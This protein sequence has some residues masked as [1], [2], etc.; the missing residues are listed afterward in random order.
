MTA[1]IEMLSPREKE[2][3]SSDTAIMTIKEVIKDTKLGESTIYELMRA[4]KFP[5]N[6]ILVGRKTVWLRSEIQTWIRWRIETGKGND[7][8]APPEEMP[9]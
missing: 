7:R 8:W 1:P 6:F 4:Q 2:A 5:E 3:F 9:Q